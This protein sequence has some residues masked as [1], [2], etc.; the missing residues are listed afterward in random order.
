MSAIAGILGR[1]D[2]PANRGALDRM[3]AAMMHRGPDASGTWV[4]RPNAHGGG[5]LLAHRRLAV[6]DKSDQPAIDDDRVLL[7]DGSIF[8]HPQSQYFVV[9]RVTREQVVD[10][11]ARKRWSLAE[12]ER[13]LAPNLDYDPE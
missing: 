10:Y 2:D 9:G 6:L 11:A 7:S 5:I 1:V 4:S 13:W 3:S 8:S 12:A